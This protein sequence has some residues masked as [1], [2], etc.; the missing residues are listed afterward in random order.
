MKMIVSCRQ[1]YA[2]LRAYYNY[3]KNPILL[4][5]VSIVYNIALFVPKTI[6]W[7]IPI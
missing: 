7:I 4:L 6:L 5:T 3:R 2:V 1:Q